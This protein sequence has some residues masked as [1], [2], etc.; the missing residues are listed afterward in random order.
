MVSSRFVSWRGWRGGRDFCKD[1][2]EMQGLE[3]TTRDGFSV[4]LCTWIFACMNWS[5]G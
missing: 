5:S 1:L 2:P 3:V 4:V